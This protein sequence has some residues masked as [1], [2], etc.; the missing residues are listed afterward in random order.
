MKRL[1]T[2]S[3]PSGYFFAFWIRRLLAGAILLGAIISFSVSAMAAQRFLTILS[4]LQAFPSVIRFFTFSLNLIWWLGLGWLLFLIGGTLLFGRWYCAFLCPLGTLQDIIFLIKPKKQKKYTS[5]VPLLR[6]LILLGTV[7]LGATGLM[8]VAGWLDPWSIFS[9]LSRH[10][11]GVFPGPLPAQGTSPV[12]ILPV[13]VPLVI[14]IVILGLSFFSSRWFCGNLCPVGTLLGFLNKHALFHITLNETNCIR[15]GRC[16]TVCRASCVDGVHKRLDASRCTYCFACIV[17]CPV[18]ALQYE[19]RGPG[20]GTSITTE[21]PSPALESSHPKEEGLPLVY[22]GEEG[23]KSAPVLT[24]AEFFQRS[25][26]ILG[27]TG[28][29]LL[30]R[31][32]IEGLSAIPEGSTVPIIPPGAQSVRHLRENCTACGLCM[33][34][35]PVRIIQPSLGKSG[36][37]GIFIPQLD[38]GVSYCQYE[39]KRC[40]DVCPTGALQKINLLEKKR[41]KI[42]DATLLRERC[43]VIKNKT[44]C[45][46]CAE[47]CPT[48]A[49]HMMIGSTGLPEPVFS[50]S[51]CIG[52]GACHHVCPAEPKAITVAGLREHTLAEEAHPQLE[53]PKGEV[54]PL[55]NDQS[56]GPEDFPF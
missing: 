48:G 25:L 14:L 39:C 50:S 19:R 47:H 30:L 5:A 6:G 56:P 21:G 28:A 4:F 8:A 49:V 41:I 37:G 27:V 38:Y 18:E 31:K 40:S 32:P 10:S 24:R 2:G 13:L 1:K 3:T 11:P 29:A 52:C 16:T 22:S 44:R 7:F 42:G 9:R 53:S 34:V 26:G 33:E 54:A 15:C 43:I 23:K 45:G 36:G 46:A 12:V 51:I 20:K 55:G 17:Q 35:C